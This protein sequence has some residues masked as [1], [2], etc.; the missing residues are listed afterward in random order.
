M[1]GILSTSPRVENQTFLSAV[2]LSGPD[3]TDKLTD[4][5]FLP[6]LVPYLANRGAQERVI[7]VSN[8]AAV[9]CASFKLQ[10]RHPSIYSVACASGTLL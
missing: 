9:P 5:S 4:T 2:N 7:L 1:M 10:S 8:I 3:V 6:L